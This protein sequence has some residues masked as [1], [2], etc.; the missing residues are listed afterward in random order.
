LC[1]VTDKEEEMPD[2]ETSAVLM[3]VEIWYGAPAPDMKVVRA[4]LL[5]LPAVTTTME[6]AT[7]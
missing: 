4:P 3:P 2:D 7:L 1:A 5:E 6:T